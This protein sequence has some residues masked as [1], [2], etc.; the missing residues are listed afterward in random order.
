MTHWDDTDLTPELREI[1]VRLHDER[2]LATPLELDELKRRAVT[3][4]T[5]AMEPGR[6]GLTGRG[7]FATVLL[8]GGLT[9]GAGSAG[10]VAGQ[11]SSGTSPS[12]AL[13]QYESEVLPEVIVSGS[14]RLTA[15]KACVSKKFTIRVRGQNIAKVVFRVDG[16]VIKTRTKPNSGTS[17][18]VRIN[19][20]RYAASGI[21]RVT[22]RVTFTAATKRA[23]RTLRA[24]F[25]RCRKNR[26]APQFTG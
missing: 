22:A 6:R 12:A 23:P 18:T 7:R 21:H 11:G 1:G 10:V 5:R 13:S 9:F 2:Y 25:E 3:Q 8:I 16:R 24:T 4:A 15:P 17:F 26:V 19:S 20:K 14:A